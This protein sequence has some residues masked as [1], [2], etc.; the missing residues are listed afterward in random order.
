MT[1]VYKWLVA[2]EYSPLPGMREILSSG[3]ANCLQHVF[4]LIILVR[5]RPSHLDGNVYNITMQIKLSIFFTIDQRIQGHA[6]DK[7]LLS[8]QIQPGKGEV[9]SGMLSSEKHEQVSTPILSY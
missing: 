4:H 1:I 9:Q 6:D 7:E 2:I 8:T 5:K 3:Q